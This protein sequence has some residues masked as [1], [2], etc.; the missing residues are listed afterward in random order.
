[1]KNIKK[2]DH[3]KPIYRPEFEFFRESNL[4]RQQVIEESLKRN[5]AVYDS[6]IEVVLR[7]GKVFIIGTVPN[8]TMKSVVENMVLERMNQLP[9]VNELSCI[10]RIIEPA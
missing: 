3:T 2:F 10:N 5:P 7:E 6:Q 4:Y 1:M 9:L 8:E